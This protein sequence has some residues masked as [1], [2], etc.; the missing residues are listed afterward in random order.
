MSFKLT[1]AS[2]TFQ[3][4]INWVLKELVDDFC[5]IYL[6]NILVFSHNEKEYQTHLKLIIEHLHQAELYANSKKCEFFKIEL[7]YLGFI[8]DK[9]GLWMDPACIQTILEW[10][11]YLPKTYCDV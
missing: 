5:V 7:E 11:N 1:N 9:N 3:A 6:D 8:I 10:H 2:T 4:F